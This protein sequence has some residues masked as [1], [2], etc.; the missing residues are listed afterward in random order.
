MSMRTIDLQRRKPG[1][2]ADA[3]LDGLQ[4]AVAAEERVRWDASGH[5]RISFGQEREDARETV[6]ARLSA[7]G[8]DW[9]E[10]I[11]IL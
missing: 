6:A 5:A 4:A 7:L 8:E 2:H 1:P 9:G 3:L 10:H 11:A